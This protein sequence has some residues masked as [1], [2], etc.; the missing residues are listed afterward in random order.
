LVGALAIARAVDDDELSSAILR[1]SRE[2]WIRVLTRKRE[3][4][5]S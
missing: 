4:S 1:G 2:F 3:V 5:R